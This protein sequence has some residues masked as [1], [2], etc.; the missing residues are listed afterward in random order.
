[1]PISQE[2]LDIVVL[3][4]RPPST[5]SV[6]HT[7]GQ[8]CTSVLFLDHPTMLEMAICKLSFFDAYGPSR[9]WPA[10]SSLPLRIFRGLGDFPGF[11]P[12]LPHSWFLNLLLWIFPETVFGS[13]E[14]KAT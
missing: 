1:M 5:A 2:A 3:M 9:G 10:I 12:H 8:R 11:A 7:L 6:S 4:S 13:S 14:T